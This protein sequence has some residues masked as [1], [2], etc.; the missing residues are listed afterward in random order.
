MSVPPRVQVVVRGNL[1]GH[2]FLCFGGAIHLGV[3]AVLRRQ[4]PLRGVQ[5]VGLS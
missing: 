3:F 5:L 4:I 2:F 1:F